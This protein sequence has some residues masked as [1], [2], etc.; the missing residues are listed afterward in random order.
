MK[1]LKFNKA[2]VGMFLDKRF[3]EPLQWRKDPQ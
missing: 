3:Y 1:E 2:E